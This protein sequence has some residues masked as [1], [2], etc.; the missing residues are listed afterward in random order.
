[1][2]PSFTVFKAYR[3]N[4]RGTFD[5]LKMGMHST[6]ELIDPKNAVFWPSL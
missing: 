5:L 2:L 3:E 1:M 4:G 6:D